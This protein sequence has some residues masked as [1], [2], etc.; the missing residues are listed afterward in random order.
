M[1]RRIAATNNRAP[2]GQFHT[3]VKAF[4]GN[5]YDGHTLGTVI[6]EMER[7]TGIEAERIYLDK[8]YQGHDYGTDFWVDVTVDTSRK[9]GMQV[10]DTSRNFDA[11]GAVHPLLS[12][13]TAHT[14]IGSI[15]FNVLLQGG[16]IAPK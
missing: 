6:A 11:E 2:G 3:H 13:G 7:W 12:T 14:Y 8:G 5:P 15:L 10:T 1:P 4:H 9:C 16:S